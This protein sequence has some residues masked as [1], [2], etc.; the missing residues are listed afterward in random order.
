MTDALQLFDL[1]PGDP[2]VLEGKSVV[3]MSADHRERNEDS[4]CICQVVGRCITHRTFRDGELIA[5]LDGGEE[6]VVRRL[7]D[8]ENFLVTPFGELPLIA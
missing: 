2:P 5:H 7:R 6:L 3:S 4:F 1:L 8:Y